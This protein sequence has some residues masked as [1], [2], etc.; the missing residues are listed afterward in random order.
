MSQEFTQSIGRDFEQSA[1]QN[2]VT[3]FPIFIPNVRG[4]L[5]RVDPSTQK[6][7]DAAKAAA[8]AAI[9]SVPDDTVRYFT[10]YP[11]MTHYTDFQYSYLVSSA[12]NGIFDAWVGF[13][14][15]NTNAVTAID[16]AFVGSGFCRGIG[17]LYSQVKYSLNC[18]IRSNW[19]CGYNGVALN[20]CM[21]VGG[22]ISYYYSPDDYAH[23]GN[24][25]T[26]PGYGPFPIQSAWPKSSIYSEIP[27]PALCG[28]PPEPE[29]ENFYGAMNYLASA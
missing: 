25:G 6:I 14:D 16:G 13:S 7:I 2:R 4:V 5:L 29:T 8:T 27:M 26:P 23:V 28:P 19:V 15:A 24:P 20:P 17:V 10:S 1:C 12:G 21:G 11:D 9:T 18:Q 22:L 3:G